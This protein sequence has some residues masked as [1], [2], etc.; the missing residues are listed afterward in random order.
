M[1]KGTNPPWFR[2]FLTQ[3]FAI[4]I[5]VNSRARCAV[6]TQTSL[7]TVVSFGAGLTAW[8]AN[9]DA[10]PLIAM[11]MWATVGPTKAQPTDRR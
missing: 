4:L 8:R 5:F 6:E 9:G 2:S 3:R 11:T 1:N 7:S 10:K